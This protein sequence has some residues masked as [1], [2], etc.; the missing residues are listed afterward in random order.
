[1][2]IAPIVPPTGAPKP[3]KP[4]LKF[5]IFPGG[6][7]I[8]IMATTFSV[9]NTAP[10]PANARA[11][12]KLARLP[13]QNPLIIDQSTPCTVSKED[14]LVAVDSSDLTTYQNESNLSESAS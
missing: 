2:T 14:I 4:K 8:P 12:A 3:K 9:T 10:I 5:R 7:V 11:M 13:V 6:K 1:M